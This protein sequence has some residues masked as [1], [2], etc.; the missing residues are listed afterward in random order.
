MA[1]KRSKSVI[2]DI[3][4]R[5]CVGSSH[6]SLRCTHLTPFLPYQPGCI[7]SFHPL[8]IAR[9]LPLLKEYV[10]TTTVPGDQSLVLELG[11]PLAFGPPPQKLAGGVG[12]DD[13]DGAI[14]LNP[15]SILGLIRGFVLVGNMV[16][17]LSSHVDQQAIRFRRQ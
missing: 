14:C 9:Q 16:V 12:S 11:I 4:T 15:F 8:E 13:L 3:V 6:L 2:S 5:V 7:G 17:V 10:V 1:N